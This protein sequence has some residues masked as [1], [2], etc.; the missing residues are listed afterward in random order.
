MIDNEQLSKLLAQLEDSGG[1]M[2]LKIGDA[3]KAVILNMEQYT[4]LT[5]GGGQVIIEQQ[6]VETLPEQP[7]AKVLVTG[8]AGYVG[9]HVTRVLLEAGYEVVVFDNL[10]TGLLEYVPKEATFVEGDILDKNL[11]RDVLLNYGITHVAHLAALL[12]VEESV[13]EP[14]RYLQVNL[15]GTVNVLEAMHETGVHNLVF[16]STAAVYGPQTQEAIPEIAT[17]NPTSPYGQ[18]KLLAEKAIEYFTK[19]L[20]LKATI[21]RFFNVAGRNPSWPISDTHHNSHLIPIVLDVVRGA[22]AQLVINGNDYPTQDG[23]CVRDY[24]HVLDIAEAHKLALIQTS[25]TAFRVYNVGTGR[26]HSVKDVVSVAAEVTGHMIPMEVG[27]RR[28][29]DDAET[30]AKVSKAEQELGFKATHSS[31]EEIIK[32]SW[33]VAAE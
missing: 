16:S 19:N 8:G 28:P 33:E 15:Q 31:L 22:Q 9:G 14:A 5:G 30:V 24:V 29:G 23:T 17:C 25:E 18:S 12:E 21:L 11:L 3:S 4:I 20:S 10:S 26:G 27:P 6:T 2:V 1:G 7:K 32:S 13:R